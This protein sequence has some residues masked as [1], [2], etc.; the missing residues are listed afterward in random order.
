ML[1][2]CELRRD[3]E[4]TDVERLPDGGFRVATAAGPLTTRRLVNAAGLRSDEVDRM[5][6]FERFTVTPR[7]GELIVLD[8]LARPLV[9]H[10]VLAVPTKVS[11]GVLVAP[12][13]FGNVMVGPTAEDVPDKRRHVLDR[14]GARVPARRRPTGSCAACSTST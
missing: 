12:T 1:A 9:R 11:K 14:G 6:G 2:G 13:V 10:I 3:T 7:R 8:K 4:V 5:L